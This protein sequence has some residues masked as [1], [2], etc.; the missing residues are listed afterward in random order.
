[1]NEQL[2]LFEGEFSIETKVEH[3]E[4][5]ELLPLEDYDSILVSLS[6]GKDSVA[7]TLH[8]LELGVPKEKIEL[9]H[10]SVDG[11]EDDIQLFD[12][13]SITSYC[14]SF[15]ELLGIPISYQWRRGGILG[16]MLRKDSLTGDV[17]YM[18]NGQIFHLPTKNGKE[19]TRLK[20]PAMSAD[21]RMRWCSAYVKI[22]VFR[23]VLNNHPRYTGTL[24]EPKKILVVTGERREESYNRSK[25]AEAEIHASN[26]KRRLV[27]AWRPCINWSEQEVWDIFERWNYFP[28]LVIYWAGTVLLAK[29]V[30][31][32]ILIYGTCSE[33]YPQQGL[34]CW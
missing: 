13:P 9:V 6:G 23:R 16:E 7:C 21:L 17:Y 18:D 26:S 25:Y 11:S 31:F 5:I 4:S 19:S 30:Y 24:E 15:S 29:H 28:R 10:Q 14:N 32:L 1:M 20:W 2:C 33:K 8:L 34:T 27:H 12:W 22:D 3:R